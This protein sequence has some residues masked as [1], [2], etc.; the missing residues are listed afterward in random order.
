MFAR[1]EQ[2][3]RL[4]TGVEN[5]RFAHGKRL[6]GL[7]ELGIFTIRDLFTHFP[8]RYDDFSKVVRI[9]DLPL[10]EKNAVLGRIHDSRG[11]RTAKG[12]YLH[13]ITV[14]DDSGM[15][16]AVWFN[17]R[18]LADILTVGREILLLGKVEHYD[19]YLNMASPLYTLVAT[20]PS[21]GTAAAGGDR[22]IQQV[23]SGPDPTGIVPVYRANGK[24]SSNWIKRLVL[25][26]RKIV[27]EPLDPLPPKLRIGR[28]L[29]SRQAAW[30][31]IHSPQSEALLTEA[32]RRLAYEQVFWLQMRFAFAERQQQRGLPA[33]SHS[34]ES[35]AID[36]LRGLLSFSLT[37]S[38]E[39][40]VRDVL[41]DMRSPVRMNRLLL[42][43]VGSG[44]TVVALHALVAAVQ[45]GRQAAMMAPTELLVSQYADSI[46]TALVELGITWTILSSSL[47]AARRQEEY[48]RIAAG[49]VQVVLGTHAL[50]E[51]EVRFRDLSLIIIDEQHRFGVEHRDR[52]IAKSPAADFLSMTA[53]PIPRSL[54]LVLYGTVKVSYLESRPLKA[55]RTT[56]SIDSS[57]A[58]R[59]YEAVRKALERGE[60]A[61]IVCPLISAPPASE[62]DEGEGVRYL[63]D[64]DGFVDE[65]FIA[66]AE[67]ELEHLRQQV[68][69]ERRVELLTSRVKSEDKQRIMSGFR[70]GE[71]DVLVSTTVIEVGVDVPNAT[72]MVILDA[73]RFGLAQLHQLRGR[74]GRG[75]KDAQVFLVSNRPGESASRRL[76]LLEK[77][78]DGLK[79]AEADLAER[80]EGDIGGTRQHGDSSLSL[81]NVVRDSNMIEAAHADVMRLLDLDPDLSLPE[82][83]H[84][85]SE[86]SVAGEAAAN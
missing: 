46:G 60:Q 64:L 8:F 9:I 51:P 44:K 67:E 31:H 43:D 34:I 42:G 35:A 2:T 70:A 12:G 19:G 27:L 39:A 6:D 5:V 47:T 18:W 22:K 45:S 79:L 62:D 33:F 56:T 41:T 1:T 30:Y 63:D 48:G 55:R 50:I 80:R 13:E 3:L 20:E 53:T 15:L 26:A 11:R 77:I 7:H 81:I 16:K 24:A 71:V 69:P 36:D 10:G 52:L 32:H 21:P 14:T 54:A 76:R 78:S 37:P 75:N 28:R 59:A 38:Q 58:Y 61:Y 86:L 65:P 29:V 40:A 83:Q 82:H 66:A 23:D 73:D 57:V 4:D 74:V 72:V 84:L 68:F 17:Q 49:E 25:E 85:R